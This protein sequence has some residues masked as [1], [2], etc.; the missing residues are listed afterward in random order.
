MDG[1]IWPPIGSD[2]PARNVAISELS[3]LQRCAAE[4]PTLPPMIAPLHSWLFDVI[5]VP[6]EAAVPS[7]D[8]VRRVRILHKKALVAADTGQVVGVVGKDYRIVTNRDALDLCRRLCEQVFPD[9]TPGEWEL[10]GASGTKSRSRVALDLKHRTHVMNLWDNAGGTSDVHTP[11]LR[12]TNSYNGRRALRFDLGFMRKHCSNGVIFEEKV[13]TVTAAHTKD[14]LAKLDLSKMAADFEGLKRSFSNCITTLRNI[15]LTDCESLEIVR[16]VLGL[17]DLNDSRPTEV[18]V[19]VERVHGYVAG[20]DARHRTEMGG[21]AYATFNTLTDFATR[22]PTSIAVRRD[23]P[24]LQGR[25]GTW[26]KAIHEQVSRPS[27][28]LNDH[29]EALDGLMKGGGRP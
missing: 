22:P 1:H 24:T 10:A 7:P 8:G 11:F 4:P 28:K 29:I 12:V 13:A 9:S 3:C 6:V 20:I 2:P 14:A 23:R 21:N 19:A 27:F 15:T 26:L 5:E 18:N 16:I 25:A 17:P